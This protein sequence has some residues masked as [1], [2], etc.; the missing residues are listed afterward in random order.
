[1]YRFIETYVLTNKNPY[2]R[3]L[4]LHMHTYFK[5]AL[6]KW[7]LI[8]WGLKSIF[9]LSWA[10]NKIVLWDLWCKAVS[11]FLCYVILNLKYCNFSYVGIGLCILAVVLW[12]WLVSCANRSQSRENRQ[13]QDHP[14]PWYCCVPPVKHGKMLLFINWQLQTICFTAAKYPW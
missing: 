12:L 2:G 14:Y 6:S 5:S 4:S 9:C 7:N 1:M 3:S 13:L 11:V 8:K 10:F